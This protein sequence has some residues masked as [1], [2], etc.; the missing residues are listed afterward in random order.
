MQGELLM[1]PVQA[2]F[3]FL[4]MTV[5]TFLASL[6]LPQLVRA[7][8]NGVVLVTSFLTM[9]IGLVWLAQAGV[10]GSYLSIVAAPMLLIGIGNGLGLGP[11]TGAAMRGVAP[12]DSGAA[13]GLVNVVH[14]LGGT[15]GLAALITIF[16]AAMKG[17]SGPG[18]ALAHGIT[19]GLHGSAV[20]AVLG[21]ILCLT[22]IIPSER[23]RR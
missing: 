3:G 11:L 14:Q 19:A 20:L 13:S 15:L 16:T 8:G 17:I 22:L 7:F 1:N 6:A 23:R 21:L 9:A 12:E 18:A 2:G 5:L 4:P 10:G